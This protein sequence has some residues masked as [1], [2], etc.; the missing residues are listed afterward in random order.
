[1]SAAESAM[2]G[3]VEPCAGADGAGRPRVISAGRRD[4]HQEIGE[5]DDRLDVVRDAAGPQ[6]HV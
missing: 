3:R 4:A 2:A 1:M 5:V 6:R